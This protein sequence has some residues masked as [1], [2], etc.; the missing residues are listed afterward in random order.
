MPTAQ[1]KDRRMRVVTHLISTL[2]LV[3]ATHAA[4]E[5]ADQEFVAK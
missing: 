1:K 3:C 2:L 4:A 5:V